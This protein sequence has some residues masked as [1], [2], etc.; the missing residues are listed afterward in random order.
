M[1]DFGSIDRAIGRTPLDNVLLALF[2]MV[3]TPWEWMWETVVG[4]IFLGGL[5]TRCYAQ[6]FRRS[7]DYFT[8]G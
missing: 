7:R 5:H 2:L 3:T 1:L 6:N 8:S 4:W